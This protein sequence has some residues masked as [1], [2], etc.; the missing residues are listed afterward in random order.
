M[1]Q[2]RDMDKILRQLASRDAITDLDSSHR[3][4]RLRRL[5][6]EARHARPRPWSRPLV[7]AISLGVLLV[8][9]GVWRDVGTEDFVLVPSSP[10]PRGER[11]FTSRHRPVGYAVTS[12][13]SD[14]ESSARLGE[15]LLSRME[16]GEGR[17]TSIFGA[18]IRGKTHLMAMGVVETSQGPQRTNLT[19]PISVNDPA[20]E[21]SMNA[22]GSFVTSHLEEVLRLIASGQAQELAPIDVTVAGKT[23]HCK[24]WQFDFADLG[25][26]IYWDGLPPP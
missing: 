19:V 16:G 5:S 6:A 17:L 24:R 9:V 22:L 11:V 3:W 26:V 1:V 7:L 21:E 25:R 18:T 15:E 8:I 23:I 13:T 20:T 12:D 10:G 4:E 2:R 14:S